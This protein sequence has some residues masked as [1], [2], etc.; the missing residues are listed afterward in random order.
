M[1]LRRTALLVLFVCVSALLQQGLAQNY[2]PA[3]NYSTQALPIAL[4]KGDFNKDGNL[5]VVV[6]NS[7]SSSLSLFPGSGDGTFGAPTIIPVSPDPNSQPVSVAAADFNGDGNLG[8][9]CVLCP[10]VIHTSSAWQW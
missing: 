3:V 7:G 10:V 2:A 8:I 9:R 4:A 5:D 6:A 1:N